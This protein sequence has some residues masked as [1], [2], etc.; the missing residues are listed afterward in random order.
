MAPSSPNICLKSAL[1]ISSDERAHFFLFASFE[2]A[3]N[4]DLRQLNY[5][6]DSAANTQFAQGHVQRRL[7]EAGGLNHL[8]DS[9]HGLKKLTTPFQLFL[10]QSTPPPGKAKPN[11]P[12]R[13]RVRPQP[14][15]RERHLGRLIVQRPRLREE[16]LWHSHRSGSFPTN[17]TGTALGAR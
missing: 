3:T 4:S 8:A 16:G 10:H 15:R 12:Q 1:P 9:R 17:A 2:M 14:Y 11:P 6:M 7:D 5:S 13:A